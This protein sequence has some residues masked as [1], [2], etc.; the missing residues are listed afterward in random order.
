MRKTILAVLFCSML[1]YAQKPSP[2][3]A[4][5]RIS[6]A[7]SRAATKALLTIEGTHNK[8]LLDAA[9]I[10]LSA[11]HSTQAELRIV[12]HIQIFEEIYSIHDMGGGHDEDRACTIAWLPKLRARSA[13]VPKQCPQMT[14]EEMKE[15]SRPS[16]P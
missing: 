13:E 8:Q 7:F 5:P 1:G 6:A 2:K 9:M 4:S 14:A 15:A 16:N 10:D 3:T 12:W 11:A